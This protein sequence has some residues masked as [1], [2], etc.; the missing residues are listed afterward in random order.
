MET[1][2]TSKHEDTGLICGLTQWV[3]DH[4]IPMSCGVGRRHGLDLM[5]LWLWCRPEATAPIQPLA[6]EPPYATGAALKRQKTKKNWC[7]TA[8]PLYLWVMHLWI[9]PG[10][11]PHI[12]LIFLY[13]SLVIYLKLNQQSMKKSCYGGVDVN[14][15]FSKTNLIKH[16]KRSRSHT[17]WDAFKFTI[18]SSSTMS[19]R[20][21]VGPVT[22]TYTNSNS[23][24]PKI[25]T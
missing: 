19:P 20:N 1:N 11:K 6:W 18:G 15:C 8:S 3:K 12:C 16:R 2:L 10:I 7:S 4:G 24:G 22:Q 25:Q 23:N 5:L 17:R 14:F 21:K 9:Q 13:I